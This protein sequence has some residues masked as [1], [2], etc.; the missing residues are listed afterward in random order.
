MRHGPHQGAQRS[1]STNLFVFKAEARLASLASAIQ[2]KFFL[3]DAHVGVPLLAAGTRFLVPQDGHAVIRESIF[4][5][6]S[7][8]AQE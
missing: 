5:E 2:G 8:M 4:R 7:A 1:I 6:S 3:H